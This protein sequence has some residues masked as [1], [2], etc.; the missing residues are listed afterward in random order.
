MGESGLV[1]T[2]ETLTDFRAR[3]EPVGAV[4]EPRVDRELARDAG[5]DQAARVVDVLV[6]KEIFRADADVGRR[7]SGEIGGARGAGVGTALV[8]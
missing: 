2:L 1:S 8:V 3:H 5:G 4:K 7:E 6:P